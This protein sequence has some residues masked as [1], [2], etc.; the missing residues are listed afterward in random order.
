MSLPSEVLQ[1]RPDIRAALQQVAAANADIGVA[2]AAMFP[3]LTINADIGVEGS[4]WSDLLQ[5][6]ALVWSLG[7]NI[8]MPLTSQKLLGHRREAVRQQHRAVS[9]EYRQAVIEAVAEVETAIQTAAILQRRLDS[10]EQAV[11]AARSTCEKSIKRY[12]A[13]LVSFL[14]VVDAERTR[15]DAERKA[16]A[17][18][19][20]SLAVS[21]SLIKAIGGR[22]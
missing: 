1:Q 14:D 10:Q 19:A 21:V 22:W 9:A 15:L 4:E 3:S 8:L 6:D 13:G 5:S 17:I 2:T 12:K 7:S 16:N 20:E 18:R 11:D